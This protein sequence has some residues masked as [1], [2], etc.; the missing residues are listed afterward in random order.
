MIVGIL[1][2][3]QLG[4][5]LALAGVPLGMR[6]RVLDPAADACAAAVAEHVH[7]PYDDARGLTALAEGAG[8]VTYEF[9]NVPASAIEALGDSV[10]VRPGLR[11]LTVLQDRLTEKSLFRDLG[12]PTPDFEP[13]SSLG[14]LRAAVERLGT[15]CVVKTRRFGYDGKGQAVIRG[16]GDTDTAWAAVGGTDLIVERFIDFEREVAII[17][18]RGTDGQHVFYDIVESHH[19]EG[20]LRWVV[21][22]ANEGLQRRAESLAA[23]LLDNLDHV[24]ALGLEFFQTA[25]GLLANEAAPR[26]HNTGHWTIDGARTSQFE[27]HMRA[28][29][30]LPL[31]DTAVTGH[32]GNVNFI[33]SVPDVADVL[34]IPGVHHHDY[35]KKPR[36]GRKVGHATVVAADVATRDETLARLREMADDAELPGRPPPDQ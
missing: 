1:G 17:G 7:A 27:N 23:R 8:V 21:P 19:R 4:R 13:V 20:I 29:A 15:P 30:G 9:E 31:D 5:M 24:G 26:V 12:I 33:G 18:V 6:V 14:E 22:L 16:T 35:G 10:P 3:G 36:A 25:E 34:A 11:S 28:I 2:G 32:V